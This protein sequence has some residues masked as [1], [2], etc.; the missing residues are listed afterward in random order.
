[1]KDGESRGQGGGKMAGC[2]LF[3]GAVTLGVADGVYRAVRIPLFSFSKMSVGSTE[4][5]EEGRDKARGGES[6]GTYE[7]EVGPIESSG[8]FNR[9][10]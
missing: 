3:F 9:V 4:G 5:G 2:L 1:M 10:C 8:K 6:G 7:I